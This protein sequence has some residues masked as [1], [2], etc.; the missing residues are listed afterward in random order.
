MMKSASFLRMTALA[1]ALALTAGAANA[2]T[3][4]INVS[5]GFSTFGAATP[6]NVGSTFS[7]IFTFT[8]PSSVT[9]GSGSVYSTVQASNLA[10]TLFQLVDNSGNI[11]A[12]SGC[13]VGS[14]CTGAAYLSP[15][16]F[17]VPSPLNNPYSLK[18][19]GSVLAKSANS[20]NGYGGSV[21]V[22]PVPEP[23]TYAMLL[24]G[25]GLL[26]F[27]ARRRKSNNSFFAY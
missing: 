15:V 2:N 14:A 4:T 8:M 7:D 5:T 19:G 26:A 23:K 16:S 17:L 13:T 22:S 27:T 11:I 9:T 12:D 10:F 24:A 21:S 3:Y 25:L 1:A 20:T 18:V 6:G